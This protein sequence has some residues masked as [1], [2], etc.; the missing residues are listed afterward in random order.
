M[1]GANPRTEGVVVEPKGRFVERLDEIAEDSRRLAQSLF[2]LLYS[3]RDEAVQIGGRMEESSSMIGS[4][5]GS[6]MVVCLT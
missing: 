1:E 5:T 4:S 3:G 6:P 2:L